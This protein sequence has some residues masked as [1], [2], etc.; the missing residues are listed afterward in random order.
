MDFVQLLESEQ[1]GAKQKRDRPSISPWKA[2]GIAGI[3]FILTTCPHLPYAIKQVRFPYF[4]ST[5]KQ[6]NNVLEALK[7]KSGKVIDLGSG[8][9]RIVLAAAR[10]G[11]HS[12][13]I[14]LNLVLLIYSKISSLFSGLQNKPKFYLRNIWNYNLQSYNNIIV[15][16]VKD[17]MEQL[18]TK[19]NQ[20][21]LKGTHIIASGFPLPGKTPIQTI[22]SGTDTVWVYKY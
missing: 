5:P 20:E 16:G 6:V 8:D 2:V 14:E 19:F 12:T 13:G 15:V 4:A 9:G 17:V 21:L 11:F 10:N 1:S 22:G 18:G 3:I 7:G